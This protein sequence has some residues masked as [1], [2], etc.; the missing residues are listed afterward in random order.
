[1][2]LNQPHGKGTTNSK[3]CVDDIRDEA[4]ACVRKINRVAR[5]GRYKVDIAWIMKIIT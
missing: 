1:M 5:R 2:K 3:M 4:G